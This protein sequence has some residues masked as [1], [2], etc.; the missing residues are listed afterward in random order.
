[1]HFPFKF[2]KEIVSAWC[3]DFRNGFYKW[4]KCLSMSM[5]CLKW[6]VCHLIEKCIWKSFFLFIEYQ[7]CNNCC[8][9]KSISAHKTAFFCWCNEFHSIIICLNPVKISC[10]SVKSWWMTTKYKTCFWLQ[11]TSMKKSSKMETFGTALLLY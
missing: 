6:Y 11:L 4:G 10:Y 5:H 8:L 1:M 9:D 7:P 3:R 2:H